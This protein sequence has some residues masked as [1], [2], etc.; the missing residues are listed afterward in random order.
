MEIVSE[1]KNFWLTVVSA[2]ALKKISICLLAGCCWGLK[3]GD[4]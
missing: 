3:P 4:R 2:L 1:W